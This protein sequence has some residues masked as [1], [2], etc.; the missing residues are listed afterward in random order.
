MSAS[1]CSGGPRQPNDHPIGHLAHPILATD[2][3]ASIRAI[4]TALH[5]VSARSRGACGV[6]GRNSDNT[7]LRQVLDWEP[8]TPLVEGLA[9]TYAWIEKQVLAQR[10]AEAITR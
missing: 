5:A 10:P 8:A 4:Q 2:S 7:R 1:D 6:R 9:R 3:R